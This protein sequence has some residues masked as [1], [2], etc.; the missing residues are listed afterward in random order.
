M[1]ALFFK[2][3]DVSYRL[4]TGGALID[5]DKPVAFFLNGESLM[6]FQGDTLAS[7]LLAHGRI[8]CAPS[9][10]YGRPR[11]IYTSCIEE[12]N[13]IFDIEDKRGRLSARPA[14]MTPLR[15]GLKAWA[16]NAPAANAGGFR[17]AAAPL[18]DG[19]SFGGLRQTVAPTP[20][21]DATAE[22]LGAEEELNFF[23]DVLVIGG[24]V[25]GISAAKAA[26]ASGARVLLVEAG[27]YF[28]GRALGD[29]DKIGRLHAATWIDKEISALREAPEA[30][31]R[32]NAE[33]ISLTGAEGA[34]ILERPASPGPLRR[35]WRVK[36]RRVVLATG[37]IERPLAFANNDLPGVM[38]ASAMRDYLGLYGVEVG[39][40]VAIFANNDDGYLTAIRLAEAGVEVAAVVDPRPDPQSALA[41][42]AA[43][44]GLPLR[45]G[46][47][48]GRAVASRAPGGRIGS[49]EI[50][51]LR[52]SGRLGGAE[53]TACDALAISGGW[54]PLSALFGEAGGASV[55]DE[56]ALTFKPEPEAIDLPFGASL[57]VAG[58]AAGAQSL[59]EA[60]SSGLGAGKSAAKAL[61]LSPARLSAPKLEAQKTDA[62]TA[63]W[64]IPS[65]PDCADGERHFVDL[66]EDLTVAELE[67]TARGSVDS[68][69]ALRKALGLSRPLGA[70]SQTLALAVLADA[71]G[72]DLADLAPSGA[73][74]LGGAAVSQS[75]ALLE[76]AAKSA[77]FT[78]ERL[79]PI[80]AWHEARGA[81]MGKLGAWRAPL[82]YPRQSGPEGE[83]E[84]AEEAVIR[85]VRSARHG[86][87]AYDATHLNRHVLAGPAAGDLLDAV[88]A[89]P[90]SVLPIGRS[91]VGLLRSEKGE[92]LCEAV[93]SRLGEC[94]FEI[95]AAD[96]AHVDLGGFWAEKVS[97]R[98]ALSA[99]ISESW[100]TIAVMGAKSRLMLERLTEADVS[101]EALAPV[102]GMEARVAAC[103]ARIMRLAPAGGLGFEIVVP[104]SLALSVWEDLFA[105]GETLGVTPLGAAAI[106]VLRIERGRPAGGAEAAGTTGLGDTVLVGLEPQDPEETPPVGAELFLGD[107]DSD[108]AIIRWL[109][110]A[111]GETGEDS[112][113]GSVTSSCWSP[114]LGRA[115]AL[116]TVDRERVEPGET[117]H[118]R[119][120]AGRLERMRIVAPQFVDLTEQHLDGWRSH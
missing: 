73:A 84:D 94:R 17:R 59:G 106:D 39:R 80:T 24:G 115:I 2:S 76:T 16:P 1:A 66:A 78:A 22:A 68:A 51:P 111:G 92:G 9:V 6:G 74:G 102:Q 36:A 117:V 95:T 8:F 104:S 12:P 47:V 3:E 19:A 14:T 31:L 65:A 110:S 96:S 35:L 4:G 33:A 63:H 71:R 81:Q 13:A 107:G 44:M 10:R 69:A 112:A 120:Q 89:E 100:S 60:L 85:E 26:V 46:S 25:A 119:D 103:P 5:R 40:R 118:L 49:V 97:G 52:A 113:V 20:A 30:A 53:N 86:V 83:M 45:K 48:V 61:G 29:G 15:P 75:R 108:P 62:A 109:F 54:S 116:A 88:F 87:A 11:G 23:A 18:L 98:D 57:E 56:E 37:A 7:A 77:A 101:E 43:E 99:D 55:W 34:L 82:H 58:S 41:E 90:V 72:A 91:L 32:L 50:A 38:T 64:I 105:V 70:I 21:P 42:H 67:R 28:G 93:A 114:T 27:G 79:S